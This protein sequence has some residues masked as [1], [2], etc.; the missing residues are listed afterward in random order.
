M[1]FADNTWR[2]TYAQIY[3]HTQ[4][5]SQPYPLLPALAL[6]LLPF[7]WLNPSFYLLGEPASFA[8]DANTH[9]LLSLVCY[10]LFSPC[11][12]THPRH[13]TDQVTYLDRRHQQHQPF[14]LT[15]VTYKNI[16]SS[17]Y[18]FCRRLHTRTFCPQYILSQVTRTFV[19]HTCGRR[20]HKGRFCTQYIFRR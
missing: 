18:I 13:P 7:I 8:H 17:I 15:Q 1:L 20:L 12:Y 19:L 4:F 11:C 6:I 16:L 14:R 5:F 3:K 2:H 9:P 10:Q